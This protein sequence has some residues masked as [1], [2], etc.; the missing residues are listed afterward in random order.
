MISIVLLNVTPGNHDKT[1]TASPLEWKEKAGV[2]AEKRV[3]SGIDLKGHQV[4]PLGR[5]RH[6]P[7]HIDPQC[8]NAEIVTRYYAAASK[9]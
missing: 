1:V 8:K 4:N 9:V 6:T 3:L 5:R 2:K 7:E